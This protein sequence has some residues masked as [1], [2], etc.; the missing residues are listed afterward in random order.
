MYKVLADWRIQVGIAVICLLLFVIYKRKKAIAAF[1]NH[2]TST[3]NIMDR[4]NDKKIKKLPTQFTIHDLDKNHFVIW[5][6]FRNRA[7]KDSGGLYTIGIGHL[8]KPDEK[9]LITA[10]LSDTEVWK[11]FYKDI[12]NARNIVNQKIKVPIT[13]GLYTALVSLAFNTGTLY[14]SIIQLIE[15]DDYNLLSETWKKTAITVNN[16]KKVVKGLINRRFAE[17]K[18]FT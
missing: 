1:M 18:L 12:Q 14:N 15:K 13:A 9:H 2:K 6:G 8:I 7:Y 16:G 17:T 4:I 5:E 11:L 3:S 10:T